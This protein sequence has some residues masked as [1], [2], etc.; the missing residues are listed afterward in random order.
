MRHALKE[1][2][3]EALDDPLPRACWEAAD[4][5]PDGIIPYIQ[6]CPKLLVHASRSATQSSS[7]LRLDCHRA[8]DER[9]DPLRHDQR[10]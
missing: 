5:I 7:R 2:E 10:K 9:V 3:T 4:R 6:G 1:A 8:T